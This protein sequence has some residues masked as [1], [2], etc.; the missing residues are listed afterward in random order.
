MTTRTR[1]KSLSNQLTARELDVLK[2]LVLG[3]TNRE[4]GEIL[5]ITELTVK[6]HRRS[7]Y[8]KT[9]TWNPVQITIWALA[10]GLFNVQDVYEEVKDRVG[11]ID[12]VG[13]N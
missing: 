1:N 11:A 7:A 12:Y 4:T 9:G 8:F 2:Y 3:Y 6:Q 13:N 5:N 10:S